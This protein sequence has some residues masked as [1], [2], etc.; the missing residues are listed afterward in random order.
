MVLLSALDLS[1][2]SFALEV[3]IY[4]RYYIASEFVATGI[5][6]GNKSIDLFIFLWFQSLE[7]KVLE[8]PFD[9]VDSKSVS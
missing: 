9:R 5:S 6:L 8:L 4:Y 2:D 3:F 7:R 1:L